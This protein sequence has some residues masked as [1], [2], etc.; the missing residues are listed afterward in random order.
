VQ[1]ALRTTTERL[2]AELIAPASSAPEW[3]DFEWRTARAVAAMHGISGV[4]AG[5]L[6]WH[7]AHGWQAFLF[8]QREHIAR[9]HARIQNLLSQIDQELR[10]RQVPGVA[11]KGAALHAEGFYEAGDRPMGDIDL[12]VDP[13][14]A[15][16]VAH[17]LVSLGFRC[18]SRSF[19]Q[20]VF[21]AQHETPPRP[22]GEHADND[23][24][25]ELHT[26][27]VEPLP[28]RLAG[29]PQHVLMRDARP[30]L[31]PYPS[32][33]A[34]VAHLLLHAAGAMAGRSLR[35][36]QLHDI[37][38]LGRCS[39]QQEWQEMLTW[40]PWWALPPLVLTERYYGP[41]APRGVLASLRQSCPRILRRV[42]SR[43]KVSDVSLS[44]LWVSAFPGLEWARSPLE[45]LRFMAGRVIPSAQVRSD[46]RMQLDSEPS[47]AEGDW[48]RLSQGGRILRF[49][50][51]RT[52]RPW[53]MHNVRAALAQRP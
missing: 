50:T 4:L 1:A 29:I 22:F 52:P 28:L 27:I 51:S 10:R 35:L 18:S 39:T 19:K 8:T 48:A 7:G 23:M 9:R 31:N 21:V 2:A 37:A 53:P 42:S 34:L 25:V 41:I 13:A 36:I 30:G 40:D 3:S 46:R 12:L 32:R 15:E 26:R 49:L 20:D 16:L 45:A 43:Q 33:A 6:R 17:V 38:L 44:H 24:K 11:L 5:R 47:L 14:H